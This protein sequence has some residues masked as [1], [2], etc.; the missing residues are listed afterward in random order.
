MT[1]DFRYREAVKKIRDADEAWLSELPLGDMIKF[2]WLHPRP[3]ASEEMTACLR[4]FDWLSA[5]RADAR[6]R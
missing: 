1:R 4:F 5:A 3:T 6:A 2:G